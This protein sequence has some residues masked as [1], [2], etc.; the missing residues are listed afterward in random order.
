MNFRSYKVRL[1]KEVTS[2]VGEE[3]E[4]DVR[5]AEEHLKEPPW[6]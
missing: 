2:T 5:H 3:Q 4:G 1:S 6:F